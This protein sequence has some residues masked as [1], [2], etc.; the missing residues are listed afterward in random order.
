LH[1]KLKPLGIWLWTAGA[2]E[3]HLGI[4]A[5]NEASWAAFQTNAEASGI[6]TICA[7]LP[8]VKG[9]IEWLCN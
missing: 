4:S 1:E 7:D 9:L 5:K 6:E 3:Q 8:S 2:I